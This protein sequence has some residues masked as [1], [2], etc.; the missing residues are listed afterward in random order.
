MKFTFL[1]TDIM[2]WL[3]VFSLIAWGWV[4]GRSPQV[5]KQWRSIFQSKIAISCAVILLFYLFFALL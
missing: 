4:I 3:L 2:V 1:W 5:K